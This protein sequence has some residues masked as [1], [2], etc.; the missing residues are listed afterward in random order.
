MDTDKH[1]H[2][3]ISKAPQEVNSCTAR[4][5]MSVLETWGFVFFWAVTSRPVDSSSSW[6]TFCWSRLMLFLFRNP[7]W[8]L[9]ISWKSRK[10]QNSI[11][12]TLV[13]VAH[14]SLRRQKYQQITV[15]KWGICHKW[16]ICGSHGD[17]I[18]W[19]EK[20]RH[21]VQIFKVTVTHMIVRKMRFKPFYQ[22]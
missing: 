21:K 20:L 10:E 19:V 14:Y 22:K 16:P 7:P 6:Y 2:W 3:S 17:S 12:L 15:D 9:R 1:G 8:L 4:I 5:Y 18:K 13:T 11:L